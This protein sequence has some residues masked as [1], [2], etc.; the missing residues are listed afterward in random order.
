MNNKKKQEVK[1]FTYHGLRVKKKRLKKGESFYVNAYKNGKQKKLTARSKEEIKEKIDKFLTSDDEEGSGM[2]FGDAWTL[3]V[4]ERKGQV[5]DNTIRGYYSWH[6]ARIKALDKIKIKDITKDRINI[7]FVEDLNGL[8][9][10]SKDDVSRI[11]LTFLKW[12]YDKNLMS[13]KIV[14]SDITPLF[15]SSSIQQQSQSVKIIQTMTPEEY[16]SY[17]K[18]YLKRSYHGDLLLACDLAFYAGLRISEACGLRIKDIM[19]DEN[20]RAYIQIRQKA[21]IRMQDGHKTTV[22]SLILKS[23]N[24]RRTIPISD[25]LYNELKERASDR[26]PDEVLLTHINFPCVSATHAKINRQI[27]KDNKKRS[28]KEKVKITTLHELRKSFLTRCASLGM[29]PY[30]LKTIAGHESIDTTLRCYIALDDA[31]AAEKAR[32]VLKL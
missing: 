27:E 26:T 23:K 6:N 25:T 28:K 12:C 8:S 32:Q 15:V 19:Q 2:L 29:D 13:V 1:A 16:E 30:T 14:K 24:A 21:A 4:Q 10:T 9:T 17:K 22:Y 3:F 11:L 31:D 18:I 5:Q 20:G 7:F